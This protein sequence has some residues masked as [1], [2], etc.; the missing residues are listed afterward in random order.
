MLGWMILFALMAVT[1]AVLAV[2]GYAG[3]IA[4]TTTSLV[5]TLLFLISLLT[6]AV[7]GRA[8]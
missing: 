7:R 2:A 3:F 4:A 1:G 6:W 5:F 8:R